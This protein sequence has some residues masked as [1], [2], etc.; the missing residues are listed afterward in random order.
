MIQEI[1]N[2]LDKII[3]ACKKHLV[4]EFYVFGS[5]LRDDFTV[6]SD[7]DFLY[8]F[9]SSK[10][11]IDTKKSIVNYA[12][13]FFDLKFNLESILKRDVDIIENKEFTNPYFRFAVQ[14]SKQL[15]YAA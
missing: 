4:K 9:D 1:A 13:N 12:D 5:A 15:I 8:E 11:S 6:T 2:N 3:E 14:H 7:I 10:V